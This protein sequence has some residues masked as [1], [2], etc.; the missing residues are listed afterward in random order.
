MI[1][2]EGYTIIFNK[3]KSVILHPNGGIT[4]SSDTYVNERGFG[5]KNG[6][7]HSSLALQKTASNGSV[8]KREDGT[9]IVSKKGENESKWMRFF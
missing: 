7:L 2:P 4:Y 8:L 5:L 6:N 1:T 9:V 3:D